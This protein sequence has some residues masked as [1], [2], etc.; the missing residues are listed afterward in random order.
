MIMRQIV[1]E[2]NSAVNLCGGGICVSTDEKC[3][4]VFTITLPNKL[5]QEK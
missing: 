5:K 2:T 4:T 1:R 3:N